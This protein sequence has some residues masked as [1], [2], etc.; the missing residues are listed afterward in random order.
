MSPLIS[1]KAVISVLKNKKQ[2]N[3]NQSTAGLFRKAEKRINFVYMLIM[4][5]FEVSILIYLLINTWDDSRFFFGGIAGG[6]LLSGIIINV[7]FRKKCYP[8][9]KYVNNFIMIF[10]IFTLCRLSEYIAL[11]LIL[12][13]FINS[14][15]FRPHFTALT[16]VICLLM[17]YIGLMSIVTP[18][19]DKNYN[20]DVNLF[21]IVLKAFDFSDE[22]SVF[23]LGGQS[24]LVIAAAAL[25]TVSVYLSASGRNFTIRQSELMQKNLSTATELNVARSI[26]EGFLS[27]D[28][29]DNDFYGVY[30][31]MTAA[32]EVGGDFYDYFLI[33]ETHLAI[34]IGDVSGHGMA[35]AMFMTLSKTLI[36]VYSQA[37]RFT[38]K[39]FGQTNRYLQN[40]NPAR[41]FVTSWL[42]IL[43]LSTGSLSYSN[44]GHN[45]PVIIRGGNPE[46]LRSK[47]NFVLGRKRLVRYKENKT[48]L[49]PGDKLILYTDGVTEA[50]SP[51]GEFFGDDRLLK[52]IGAE[53][54]HDQ[55]DVVLAL[56]KAVDEFE[57]GKEHCDDATILALYFKDFLKVT[58][59]DSKT[60]FLTKKSFDSVTEYVTERCTAAG[61]DKATTDK[62]AIATSEILANIDSY[63]Y[64]SGGE[65]EIMTKCLD[66]RMIIVFRDNGKPFNPL[67]VKN[68]DVTL[69]LS[70]RKPGGLG[71]YIVKKLM[72]ETDYTYQNGQ[73]V[74][75]IEMDF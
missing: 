23:V 39:I 27:T 15:Y 13:P 60:F 29:P 68:P 69:P 21:K 42:G 55:T 16:G 58:P 31:D 33:D 28:F 70:Q 22:V 50:Q 20:V 3:L 48:K 41:L 10:S 32:T 66:R 45:Y 43:D 47:P 36:K 54:E 30:A 49:Y 18:V 9:I 75:T 62:I 11:M 8:W 40:S 71:I 17:M 4:V 1:D 12:I 51:D 34:V 56:R 52:V 65:I 63:A 38:D 72:S 25:V 53:K 7:V 57:S 67:L 74:L 6:T 64:E 73:N 44:A 35:A 37:N 24:F 2:T 46:F 61:C 26:Q 5:A 14:F 59:P 19:Y